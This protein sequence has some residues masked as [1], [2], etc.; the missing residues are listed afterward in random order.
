M[1]LDGQMGL[2]KGVQKW[3][4][5]D[6]I[7]ILLK[8]FGLNYQN[9]FKKNSLV[10]ML[11]YHIIIESLIHYKTLYEGASWS[12]YSLIMDSLILMGIKI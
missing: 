12:P 9:L 5:H 11:S 1:F 7:L 10:S 6:N 4:Q 8:E 3:S 2:C